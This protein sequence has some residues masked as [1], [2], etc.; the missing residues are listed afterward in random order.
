MGRNLLKLAM[1]A[2]VLA[3]APAM[4]EAAVT[5]TFT[6]TSS[7]EI[8]NRTY[9]GEF[10]LTL[11]D[12]IVPTATFPAIALTSCT[13]AASD[14][15]T[16]QCGTQQFF[17][18]GQYDIVSFGLRTSDGG[19]YSFNYFFDPGAL[20][21]SG[22]YDTIYIDEHAGTLVVAGA[23]GPVGP[24]G[25]GLVPEPATWALML[26]GFG[27]AGAALRRRKAAGIA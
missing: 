25:P 2:A 21:A 9:T 10:V 13:A 5:Y 19:F 26:G 11:A 4:A 14:G 3:G 16:T 6:A 15:V 27:L 8:D 22:S 18:S 20:S 7:S 24:G 23:P 1:T 12:Y 17:A